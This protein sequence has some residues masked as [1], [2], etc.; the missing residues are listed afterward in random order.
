MTSL[1]LYRGEYVVTSFRYFWP[2]YKPEN[3]PPK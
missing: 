3:I 2:N 1:S